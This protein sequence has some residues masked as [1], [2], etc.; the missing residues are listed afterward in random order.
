METQLSYWRKQLESLPAVIN[1]PSDRP[2]PAV[3]SYQGARQSIELSNE[4][5]QNLKAFSRK[6]D[7]TPFMTLLAAFQTLLYRY[8]SQDDIVVGS[9][10]AG[11][12]RSEIEG[13]IGFF[14]NT[15]VLR[16]DLSGD[17]SFRELLGRVRDV[18][19]GA[20]AH[21]DLP[22]EKLVEELKPERNL[23]H[24]PLFQVMFNMVNVGDSKLDLP[25]LIVERFSNSAAQSKFD[26]TLY[27][28]EQSGRLHLRVV[29]KTDLFDAARM[30][31][32]LEQLK[33]LLEQIVESADERISSYSLVTEKSRRLLPDPTVTIPEHHFE[34]VTAEFL[35]W[36]NRSPERTAV[37][38]G[39]RAWTYEELS[40]SA[41]RI[42]V[43]LA[44]Q[45]IQR[46][47]TVAVT[48][49]RSFG[50]IGSILGVFL[51]GGVLL[52][53]DPKL[54]SNRRRLMIE[55]G[56]TKYLLYVGEW[57]Q[58][59]DWIGELTDLAIISDCK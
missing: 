51:S 18:A 7:V 28:Q 2:R 8:T 48:G 19:L 55:T 29:Y 42:A 57:R 17:P 9:P 25:G 39:A 22:F 52:T 31:E 47:E 30:N 53:I 15:L 44:D 38:Q 26:L 12:N 3:Q 58:E 46:G 50:L 6:N 37:C 20:Y 4:L 33:R 54:P 24:S 56:R 59:D 45:G 14:V 11:R 32:M 40:G 13:L 35:S 36:A 23:S 41:S 1:L 10:I 27:A 43:A 34:P 49:P 16:T 21:E 5:T